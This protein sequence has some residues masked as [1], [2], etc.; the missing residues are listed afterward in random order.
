DSFNRY[1]LGVGARHE[2]F[3]M[4]V[5]SARIQSASESRFRA[6]L[7]SDQSY[8]RSKTAQCDHLFEKGEPVGSLGGYD[9]AANQG[10]HHV[11][12]LPLKA[13]ILDGGHL[14]PICCKQPNRQRPGSGRNLARPDCLDSDWT[15][16]FT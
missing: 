9:A 3:L 14:A 15:G 13:L 10:G 12:D 7:A 1:K 16:A 6:V 2:D 8:I 11:Q 4:R 5:A